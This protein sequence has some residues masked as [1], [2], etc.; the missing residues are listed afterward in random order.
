MI[1]MKKIL[2]L[3]VF[4]GFSYGKEYLLKG[5][6]PPYLEVFVKKK[7]SGD[8]YLL[9]IPEDN[10]ILNTLTFNKDFILE[11]NFV[12]K[13]LAIPND[14]CYTLRWDLKSV[15]AEKAWDI[16]TGSYEVYVALFDT[17]VDYNNPD[18]KE[19]LWKNPDEVCDDGIDNDGNGYVDDCYGVNVLCYPEGR[20]NPN[21]KGCNAPDALDDD[22]HGTHIAGIIGA[23]GNNGLLIPG[24]AWNVKIIPCKFLSSRGFGNVAGE[25]A[26]FEY[27]K[28]LI[29][30]KGL[31]IVAVNASYGGEYP[32]SQIQY[33]TIKSFNGLYI[34][35]AGN[36][37]KNNDTIDFYPCNYNLKNKICVGAY[38][39]SGNPTYFS[40][41]GYRTVDIFAPGED[42]ASLYIGRN[43]ANCETSL[44]LASGTSMAAPFITGAVALLF[45]KNPNISFIEAKNE[46]LLTGKN[47]PV[48]DGKSYTCNTLDLYNLLTGESSQKAC[49][50]TSEIN[51]GSVNVGNEKVLQVMVRSTG[52][53][54]LKTLNVY[55]QG[56]GFYIKDENCTN[57]LLS[58]FEEC[59]I[60][61]AFKPTSGKDFS[62]LLYINFE[63]ETRKVSLSGQGV[64]IENGGGGCNSSSHE[65]V[66]ITVVLF[67]LKR[68]FKRETP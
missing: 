24:V 20:Y 66:W 40:H 61:V 9:D 65:F 56:E 63:N 29:S 52:K 11:E 32:F 8:V 4:L 41:Y 33:D 23:L 50:S 43:T 51:F 68:I 16:T 7:I 53:K 2:L 6:L 1:P 27:I 45:S 67:L 48:Y 34:T 30:K 58:P 13:A 55:I 35:A 57:T 17:G 19:N 46:I 26:C 59:K 18:L 54:Q 64:S 25:I 62:G 36:E 3:I 12:L 21:A 39:R 49:L 44:V 60:D 38:N 15:N 28:T 22:G 14:T 31:R 42:I 47:S 10:D 37:G 5:N